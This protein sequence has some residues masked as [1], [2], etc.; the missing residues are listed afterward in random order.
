MEEET[1][2]NIESWEKE[3]GKPFLVEGVPFGMF[4]EQ[5]WKHF[6]EQKETE[7]LER[8][9]FWNVHKRVL[10]IKEIKT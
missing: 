4:V 9:S 3:N 5:Q 2:E 10:Q 8:V 1:K 6:Y 7:K